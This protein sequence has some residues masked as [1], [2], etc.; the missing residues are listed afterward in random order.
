MS[1]NRIL[2]LAAG[3]FLGLGINQG[4]AMD[5]MVRQV[6]PLIGKKAPVFTLPD[7]NA[8]NNSLDELRAGKN[9]ILFFWATWC[10]HCRTQLKEIQANQE[11]FSS[12]NVEI[13]LIDSGERKEQIVKYLGQLGV[14][15]NVYLDLDG[16][17]S[18]QYQIIGLPTFVFI[19]RQ[20][21]I[22]AV[23]HYLPGNFSDYFIRQ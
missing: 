13:V 5:P 22:A 6:N 7:L 10:P 19:N 15:L 12:K 20:G 2:I 21:V 11:Q 9:T 23:E 3:F 14:T 8:K 4:M 17:V 18:D 16:R 1:K